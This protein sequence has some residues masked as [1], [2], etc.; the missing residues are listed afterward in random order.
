M[1][2]LIND[3]FLMICGILCLNLLVGCADPDED[4]DDDEEEIDCT[5]FD[6]QACEEESRCKAVK[7]IQYIYNEEDNCVDKDEPAFAICLGRDDECEPLGRLVIDPN[8]NCW[9]FGSYCYFPD[10]WHG[11][12]E[13]EYEGHWCGR[14]EHCD[15]LTFEDLYPNGDEEE[16]EEQEDE[17]DGDEELDDEEATE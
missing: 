15:G 1:K 7:A 5:V 17:P 16:Q 6:E 2:S 11:A 4:D 8:G 9:S 14:V 10:T 12:T 3:R 13:K